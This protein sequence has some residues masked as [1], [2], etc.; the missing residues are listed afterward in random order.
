[1]S[2]RLRTDR[3]AFDTASQLENAD[4]ENRPD[5]GPPPL[6]LLDVTNVAGGNVVLSFGTG[7]EHMGHSVLRAVLHMFVVPAQGPGLP[8]RDHVL[9]ALP[10]PPLRDLHPS[11]E[12]HEQDL[13]PRLTAR[14]QQILT[15]V[16]DGS[17]NA[18]IARRLA[19]S[20]GTVR[21]HLENTYRV[22]GVTNR[23]AAISSLTA[24]GGRSSQSP[25]SPSDGTEP[26]RLS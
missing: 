9:P 14:Q 15:L 1:M 22:L 23:I 25:N 5:N 21:K 20:A 7:T 24:H 26:R 2:T 6:L 13:A 11:V 18:Q 4:R 17:T 16:A 3:D 8:D 19:I 10:R 12:G